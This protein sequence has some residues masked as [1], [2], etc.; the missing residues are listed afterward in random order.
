MRNRKRGL[1]LVA[2]VLSAAVLPQTLSSISEGSGQVSEEQPEEIRLR[3]HQ[4]PDGRLEYVDASGALRIQRGDRVLT[5][6][7]MWRSSK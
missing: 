1:A 3:L 4:G 5:L 2:G 6:R 7:P